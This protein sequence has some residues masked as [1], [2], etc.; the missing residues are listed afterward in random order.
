MEKM[1]LIFISVRLGLAEV[2]SDYFPSLKKSFDN[3][4]SIG[5]IGGKKNSNSAKGIQQPHN[6]PKFT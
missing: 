1:G 6:Y 2:T 4:E 5:F 3:K